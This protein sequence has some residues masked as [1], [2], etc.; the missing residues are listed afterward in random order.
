L[1]QPNNS[2]LKKLSQQET[3]DY[4]AF[5][6]IS[7]MLLK[8][9][10]QFQTRIHWL[11]NQRPRWNETS[12]IAYQN[13]KAK[14]TQWYP[15][16]IPIRSSNLSLQTPQELLPKWNQTDFKTLCFKMQLSKPK[17]RGNLHTL[18]IQHYVDII[19]IFLSTIQLQV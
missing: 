8:R 6:Y 14:D 11:I 4:I 1:L 18:L 10:I 17:Q 15:H 3:V 2:S 9:L 5:I 7:L 19:N 16:P 13:L 12:N